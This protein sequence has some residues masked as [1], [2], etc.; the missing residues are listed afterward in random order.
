MIS[1][2]ESSRGLQRRVVAEDR[3]T[4]ST[5][6]VSEASAH[7]PTRATTPG[8]CVWF[9]DKYYDQTVA[10]VVVDL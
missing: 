1:V 8:L 10:A 7:E 6:E 9:C 2:S 5:A 4:G 3:V